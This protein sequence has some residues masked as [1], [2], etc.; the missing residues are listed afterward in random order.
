MDIAELMELFL[1]PQ[2]VAIIGVSRRTGRGSFNIAENLLELGFKGQIYPV[3]PNIDSILG[4]KVYHSVNVLPLGIDLAIVIVA[5][6]SVPQVVADG[7]NKG[8]KAFIVI[9]EGFAEADKEGKALQLQI[10]ALAKEKGARIIGP[11]SLGIVNGF[12]NFSS[13]L[14]APQLNTNPIAFVCQSGGFL[15]GFSEFAPGK[16][17]DLGNMCDVDFPEVLEYLENDPETKI[18]ALHIEGLKEGKKLLQVATRV[19]QKKPILV[20]KTGRGERASRAAASHTG[21]LSGKDDVYRTAFHQAG[22]TQVDNVDELGDITKAFLHLPLPQGNRV[23]IITP[24]GGGATMS[25]DAMEQ[26]GFELAWLSE[27]TINT[28]KEF[29][30]TWSSP[31]NPIDVMAASVRHGYKM[32][33]ST[34]LE[35]LLGDENVDAILCIAGFPTLKTIKTAV[36]GRNKPV[37]TWILGEWGEN[38]LS[39]RKETDY[40]VVYPSPERAFR[41]LAALRN[42]SAKRF[43]PTG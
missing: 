1:K 17:I 38:L 5:R 28:I 35:A 11:N 4:L 31:R 8:I 16:G 30:P 24:S 32:V 22:I 39:K 43:N 29:F 20:L 15:E 25:L 36:Y 21:S 26:H 9:T 27:R 6:Q 7:I 34:S 41:A 14:V 40:Q 13:S 18:I 19:Q 3:N 37:I 33:Y 23:A 10:V 2:S 42:Y 12:Y